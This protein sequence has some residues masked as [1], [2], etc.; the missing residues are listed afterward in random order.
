M[1]KGAVVANTRKVG[2]GWSLELAEDMKN[3]HGMD[4][5][6]EMINT[7]AYEVQ[8]QIDRQ[9]LKEMVSA[10]ISGGRISTWSPANADGRN[11]I[12]RIGTLYTHMLD[13][14]NEIAVSTRRGP[15]TFA[16]ASAKV[17]TLIERVGDFT[18][19]FGGSKVDTTNIGV[20]RV[21][22]LRNGG[23]KLFESV[24]V[25]TRLIASVQKLRLKDE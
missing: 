6:A 7:S 14:S 16:I 10:A 8:A 5:E 4:V 9:L 18:D 15:A 3:M 22:T 11:Q 24:S 25:E 1:K 20:A 12:E 19:A 13:K 2:A 21:G 23:M 17:C